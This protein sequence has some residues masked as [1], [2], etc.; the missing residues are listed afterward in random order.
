MSLFR[1]GAAALVVAVV[2]VLVRGIEALG[3]LMD[4]DDDEWQ[5]YAED[6]R[7]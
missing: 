7:R 2:W 6:G 4:A 3:L 5:R 1:R